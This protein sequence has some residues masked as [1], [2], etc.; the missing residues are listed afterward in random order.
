VSFDHPYIFAPVKIA[1]GLCAWCQICQLCALAAAGISV[2][3]GMI[4]RVTSIASDLVAGCDGRQSNSSTSGSCLVV[5]NSSG[6]DA[7]YAFSRTRSA[8]NSW[9]ASCSRSSPNGGQGE[10]PVLVQE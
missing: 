10:P 4:G 3:L 5:G 8:M 1:V 2:E 9:A 6:V 7:R